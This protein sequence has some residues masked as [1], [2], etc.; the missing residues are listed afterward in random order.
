MHSLCSPV[1]AHVSAVNSRVCLTTW[2]R[3]QRFS[4]TVDAAPAAGAWLLGTAAA[5]DSFGSFPAGAETS[6]RCWVASP[7]LSCKV[8][9]Q[10]DSKTQAAFW[11]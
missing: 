5:S 6:M 10:R 3:E 8:G 2:H 11:N 4:E 7:S 9:D 1:H